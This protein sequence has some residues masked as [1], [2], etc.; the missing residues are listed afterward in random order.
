MFEV[1]GLIRKTVRN[2]DIV[3]QCASVILLAMHRF[4]Q[5]T[6]V[7]DFYSILCILQLCNL[8]VF[9]KPQ[10]YMNQYQWYTSEETDIPQTF[11]YTQNGICFTYLYKQQRMINAVTE[12]QLKRIR[13]LKVLSIAKAHHKSELSLFRWCLYGSVDEIF[14]SKKVRVS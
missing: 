13:Q 4:H 12:E 14:S 10:Y 7:Y 8:Y 3:S 6:M 1:F 5:H 9:F 2:H 11:S